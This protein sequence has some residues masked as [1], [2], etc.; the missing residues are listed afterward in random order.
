MNIDSITLFLDSVNISCSENQQLTC[1]LT[2]RILRR[3]LLKSSNNEYH[4][5]LRYTLAR[6]NSLAILPLGLEI[7]RLEAELCNFPHLE[8][9]TRTC[10]IISCVPHP[11]STTS[12]WNLIW[13]YCNI[14]LA[15]STY[16]SL[17]IFLVYLDSIHLWWGASSDYYARE[18][19]QNLVCWQE[20]S[21]SH[22]RTIEY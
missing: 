21:F 12:T 17:L 8:N 7:S 15:T 5:V 20:L 3:P 10:W 18:F 6:S 9:R 13:K 16:W 2:Y 14:I 19:L 4:P 1:L 11:L 22:R